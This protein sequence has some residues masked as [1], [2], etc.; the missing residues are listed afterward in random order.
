VRF[1]GEFLMQRSGLFAPD[2]THSGKRCGARDYVGRLVVPVCID[3]PGPV[4]CGM[5]VER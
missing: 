5:S 4:R 3:L 2:N 1:D